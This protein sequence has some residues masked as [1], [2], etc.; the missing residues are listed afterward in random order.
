MREAT[1]ADKELS[2]SR[3]GHGTWGQKEKLLGLPLNILKLETKANGV[4]TLRYGAN[5]IITAII[6]N[7][8]DE[9][10]FLCLR[11]WRAFALSGQP[12]NPDIL[13]FQESK[14]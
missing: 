5:A 14:G 3:G 8:H 13:H 11:R 9:D 10:S 12:L 2:I 1:V 6:W 4:R 7:T